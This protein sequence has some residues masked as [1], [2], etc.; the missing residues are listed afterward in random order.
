MAVLPSLPRSCR[1]SVRSSYGLRRLPKERWFTVCV[2]FT[3][4]GSMLVS[5]PTER[6]LS[7]P[8]TLLM[9]TKP[10]TVQPLVTSRESLSP[11]PSTSMVSRIGSWLAPTL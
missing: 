4:S 2:M 7:D 6:N 1:S 9:V 11:L 8:G 5:L 10:S 3:R